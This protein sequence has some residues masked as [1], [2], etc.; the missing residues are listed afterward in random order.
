[1]LIVTG[2]SGQLGRLVVQHLLKRVPAEQIGVSL[3]D[4]A[5][6]ADLA[7]LGIRVR[8]GDYGD[9]DS[10]RHAFEGAE[11]ILMVSSNA[12]A[13]G[14]DSRAQHRNAIAAAKE[15]G[16]SRVLYTSQMSSSADSHFPPGREHAA[17][18]AML[19]ESGLRW[20]ALR[21]GFYAGSALMMNRA[22]FDQGQLVGPADG[23]V[24]WTTHDDLAAVD[25]QLLAAE[26]VIDGPTP[27]LT[28]TEALDLAD[29][30]QI[31]AEILGKPVG[32]EVIAP[33]V[34]AAAARQR[35]VPEPSVAIMVGYFEAAHAGEF[36]TPD[37]TL[38]Q[39]LGRKPQRMRDYLAQ[40]LVG[41]RAQ[42]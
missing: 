40:H 42:A 26:D 22:G 19:A 7:Q 20:T 36:S 1:M 23:K 37:P 3:R 16:A 12:A 2:A 4:P 11:R 28:G 14:G 32:R 29:L 31:G 13:T 27:P 38:E 41:E 17:T 33:E 5:S 10:L 18:E 15:S 9:P 25:A 21:H 30:A 6:A 35:G 24:V 34:M 39:L 8:A